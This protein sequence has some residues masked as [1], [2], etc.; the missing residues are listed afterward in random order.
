MSLIKIVALSD[1]HGI[2]PTINRKVDLCLIGGDISPLN[3]QFDMQK[4]SDWIFG[5]FTEWLK[6]IPAEKIILIAGNHD[7]W[8]ERASDSQIYLLEK[9]SGVK[10][11]KNESYT[12]FDDEAVEWSIFGTPY[13]HIFGRWPFMRSDEKLEEYFSKIPDNV[14]IIL[15][16]DPPYGIGQTDVILTGKYV[17]MQDDPHCGNKILAKKLENVNFKLLVFGHIHSGSHEL[18][19]Y[20]KGICTNISLLNEKYIEAYQ[21]LYI[22]LNK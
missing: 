22:D 17:G 1:L 20:N 6:T 2:L 5:I 10:Y 3:I 19:F 12:Y 14:D 4:M 21:P 18:T 13:C 16:H 8:F 15:S 7:A 11:L 9:E